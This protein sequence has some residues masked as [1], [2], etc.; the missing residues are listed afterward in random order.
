MKSCKRLSCMTL[1]LILGSAKADDSP[2]PN[3]PNPAAVAALVSAN[4]EFA[5]QLFQSLTAAEPGN[6]VFSPY[7]VA[8]ALAMAHAGA[9]GDTAAQLAA[10]LHLDQPPEDIAH[11]SALLAEQLRPAGEDEHTR[12][13]SAA[14]LWMAQEFEP[15]A[16]FAALLA[17]AYHA[18]IGRSPFAADPSGAADAINQW[19]QSATAQ[20]IDRLVAADAI[21][22]D[23]R[24]LLTSAIHFKSRWE[25][26]FDPR[27]THDGDFLLTPDR[28]RRVPMMRKHDY[29]A[30]AQTKDE[31]IVEIPFA[32]EQTMLLVMPWLAPLNDWVGQLTPAKFDRW[33]A[34]VQSRRIVLWVPRFR[35]SSHLSL[36]APLESLGVSAAFTTS[37]NFSGIA[38]ESLLI[39]DVLHQTWINVDEAG[40][41][42]AAATAIRYAVGASLEDEPT[43]VAINRPFVFAIR[44]NATGQILFLG[45]VSDPAPAPTKGNEPRDQSGQ[46]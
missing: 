44:D 22:A 39:S 36:R 10:A 31:L 23:T 12:L 1:L 41:E 37:A 5:C 6:V 27:D 46:G 9:A 40:A 20:R 33:Q 42:A 38:A 35:V 3:S 7:N 45:K 43:V 16:E 32:G 34:A 15:R 21:S 17:D 14:R 18:E 11:A 24:L 2:P 13:T 4:N 19:I 29:L 26:P 30:Y 25:A 28:H 8:A